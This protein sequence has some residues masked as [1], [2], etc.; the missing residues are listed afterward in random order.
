MEKRLSELVMT[1]MVLFW[2]ICSLSRYVLNVLPQIGSP[3]KKCGCNE[4]MMK[5]KK[6]GRGKQEPKVAKNSYRAGYA[7]FEAQNMKLEI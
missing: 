6:G 7:F 1:R 3:Y 2:R 5:E 4:G